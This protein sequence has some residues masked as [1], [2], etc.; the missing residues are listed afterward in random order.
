MEYYRIFRSAEILSPLSI[1]KE[2]RNKKQ[3]VIFQHCVD[4]LNIS[5]CQNKENH[6]LNF[7]F[8]MIMDTYAKIYKNNKK[9]LQNNYGISDDCANVWLLQY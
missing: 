6:V 7:L 3:I 9:A 5:E 1:L 2:I 8:N 4:F